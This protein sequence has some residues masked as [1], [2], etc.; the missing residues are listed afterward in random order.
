M[1]V[2]LHNDSDSD[3][4]GPTNGAGESIF[5]RYRDCLRDLTRDWQLCEDELR[6]RVSPAERAAYEAA[7]GFG[8]AHLRRYHT[9][10]ELLD[11]YWGDPKCV[12][13]APGAIPRLVEPSW[14]VEA[15]RL[16]A[17]QYKL[18]TWLIEAVAYGRR[19]LELLCEHLAR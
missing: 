3:H 10:P 14:K 15:C 12:T 5:D 8:L 6:E 18:S 7:I 19:F 9:L 1:L 13:P 17:G 11:H 4:D 2:V 16:H